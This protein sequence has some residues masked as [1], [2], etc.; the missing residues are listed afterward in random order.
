MPWCWV[1]S[2]S[3]IGWLAAGDYARQVSTAFRTD[4]ATNKCFYNLGPE[5]MTMMEAL[6]KFCAKHY[7]D[8]K[9]EVVS[10]GM[11]KFLSH[12]PGMGVLKM[13]IP[14]F[15]YFAEI[16]EDVDPSEANNL[17]GA[18]ATSIEQWLDGWQKPA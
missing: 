8:L 14:F 2:R 1:S 16:D 10:F 17:L 7:P 11:A 6:K 5:K 18:N 15:E 9:P 3:K 13:V 12:M 4:A